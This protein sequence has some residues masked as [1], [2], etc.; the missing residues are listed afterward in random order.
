MA[1]NSRRQAVAEAAPPVDDG[2]PVGAIELE[3]NLADVEKPPELP[4]GMYKAEVQDVQIN[5]SAGK[6]NRYF[7]IRLVVPPTEIPPH[8]ADDFED[9]AVLFWNRQL[10]PM[11]NDRRTLFNLRKLIE[12]FG[13]DAKTSTIDPNDW[14]GRECM[15]RVVHGKWQGE[16]RAEIKSIEPAEARQA[17][18]GRQ[19]APQVAGR[20]R[21]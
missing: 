10:V 9:G 8:L 21:R 15:I 17:A 2:E 5:I 7:A 4:A 11:G 6:G 1:K 14:M 3:Q 13:L 20:A 16:T 12:A 18:R 19:E